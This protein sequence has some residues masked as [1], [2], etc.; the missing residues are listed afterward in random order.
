MELSVLLINK[1][2][3]CSMILVKILLDM[4]RYAKSLSV[5]YL[6]TTADDTHVSSVS[7]QN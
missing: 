2:K 6:N 7:K 1:I 5:S 4:M 3:T